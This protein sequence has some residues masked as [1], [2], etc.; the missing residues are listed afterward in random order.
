MFILT[1]AVE[2]TE[3]FFKPSDLWLSTLYCALI[4]ISF[5]LIMWGK[6]KLFKENNK[7]ILTL[8]N[9][10]LNVLITCGFVV[11]ILLA[12]GVNVDAII[13][14]IRNS[15]SFIEENIWRVVLSIIVVILATIL[16][17]SIVAIV[18]AGNKKNKNVK[19]QKTLNKVISS[20][21]K[22]ILV[23]ITVIIIL[24]IFNIDIMPALAG[25]GIAG[26]VIGLG[27][28]KLINDFISGAFIIFEHH[29]DVGDVVE[30]GGFKG[31]VIDIGLKTTKIRNWQGYVKIMSNSDV[32][33]VINCSSENTT[34]SIEFT[35][36]YNEDIEAVKQLINKEL[37][38]RLADET[39]LITAPVCNGVN[40]LADSA[41]VLN[42]VATA[43]PETHYALRRR[44]NQ[45][46]KEILDENN[47][48]I[49]FPQVVVH[50]GE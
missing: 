49:P 5:F 7:K 34:F 20:I 39:N 40:A 50:K 30:V 41:I 27:A 15:G 8:V 24:L 48:E 47:I 22:Y 46:I 3:A 17:N 6:Q 31:E 42:V 23:I 37:P 25:L 19:R 21:I 32:T 14:E 28:Q 12:L 43:L 26:L 1:E 44:M 36:A 2:S 33:N 29:F 16:Y 10:L 45:E 38:K 13:N 4:I 35:I 11:L 18:H 9:I